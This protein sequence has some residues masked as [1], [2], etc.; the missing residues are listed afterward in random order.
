MCLSITCWNGALHL[1]SIVCTAWSL[2]EKCFM[3]RP[4]KS[5]HV[6]MAQSIDGRLLTQLCLLY[7]QFDNKPRSQSMVNY[8]NY[9]TP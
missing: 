5:Q 8:H 6:F 7:V 3:L 9:I 1:Q 2:R 4:L